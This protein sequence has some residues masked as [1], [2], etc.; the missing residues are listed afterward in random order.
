MEIPVVNVSIRDLRQ[1]MAHRWPAVAIALVTAAA[2]LSVALA[3][4]QIVDFGPSRFT[5]LG[6]CD[7]PMSGSPCSAVQAI[8]K[9]TDDAGLRATAQFGTGIET[10]GG[11]IGLLATSTNGRGVLA[12]STN[13]TAVRAD[14]PVGIE[15]NGTGST[16]TGLRANG[17]AVA[18]Q[19]SSTNT[20]VAGSGDKIGVYGHSLNGVGVQAES[21]IT[22]LKATGGAFGVTA[23]GNNVGVNAEGSGPG[24]RGVFATSSGSR[25]VAVD[26]GSNTSDGLGAR[27]SGGRAQLELFPASTVGAPTSGN[28]DRGEL[29]LD[30]NGDLFLCKQGGTPGKWV[31]IG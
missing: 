1:V 21:N 17:S 20:A 8:S 3:A 9:T 28:H 24:A 2:P 16:G 6:N 29:F 23:S 26:G 27:F 13:S 25:G 7:V 19:A 5:T 30:N 10:D 11:S 12:R 18:V 14:G 22:A 15:A 31:K 4:V